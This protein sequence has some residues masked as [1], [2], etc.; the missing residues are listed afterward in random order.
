MYIV[1]S[2]ALGEFRNG[3]SDID[4]VWILEKEPARDEIES[5]AEL[6][7]GLMS[8]APPFL[9]GVYAT[10]HRLKTP[11]ADGLPLPFVVNGVFSGGKPCGDLNP[12][13]R[14]CLVEHGVTIFGDHPSTLGIVTTRTSTDSWIRSNLRGYWRSWMAEAKARVD[15]RQPDET[16][17]AAALS[18]GVLGVSRMAATL[19]TGEIIGKSAAGEWAMRRWP[20]WEPVLLAALDERAGHS[21]HATINQGREALAYMTY[22]VTRFS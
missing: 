22:I 1:G 8:Y 5:L 14:Q 4:A 20:E 18:W 16:L 11:A 6:H 2:I 19:E 17:N 3:K 12:V 13:L 21:K 9:D 7:L 15:T 10:R